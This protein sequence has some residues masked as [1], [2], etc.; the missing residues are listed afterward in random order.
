MQI[1]PERVEQS[2]WPCGALERGRPPLKKKPVLCILFQSICLLSNHI[3][4]TIKSKMVIFNK[5]NCELK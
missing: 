2:G 4:Y 5:V 1:D 3:H